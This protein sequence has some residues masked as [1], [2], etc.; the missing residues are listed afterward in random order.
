MKLAII[1]MLGLT[2]SVSSAIDADKLAD[3]IYRAEGGSRAK[4]PYGILSVKTRDAG[5]ARR[6]CLNT[7]RNNHCR[8]QKAGQPGEFV[9]YLGNV[10]CPKSADPVGNGNWRRNVKAIMKKGKQ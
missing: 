1:A 3:A 8:W 5:H 9:D 2:I 4:V 10:Y 6:V 7:I